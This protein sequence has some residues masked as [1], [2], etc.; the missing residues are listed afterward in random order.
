MPDK[1]QFGIYSKDELSLIKNTFADNDILL[2]TIRKVFLQFPLTDAEKGLIRM[3]LT[4]EV[5]S[6]LKK[7]MLPDIG[8]EYPLGQLPSILSTLTKELQSKDAEDMA[9]QFAAKLIETQ[10]LEERFAALKD[11]D[12]DKPTIFLKELG[13]LREKSH[14][15]LHQ[16][17]TAYLFLLGYIDP[18]LNMIKVLAGAKDETP[19]EQEKRLKRDSTA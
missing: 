9:P 12:N 11:L 6:V 16:D 17:M 8:P 7:R 1:D 13:Y 3:A 2:Y 18:S 10:Y 5:Y 4:P 19:E 15:Q 14:L